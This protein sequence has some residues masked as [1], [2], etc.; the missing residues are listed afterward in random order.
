MNRYLSFYLLVIAVILSACSQ[1]TSLSEGPLYVG[2][3][4]RDVTPTE[5]NGLLPIPGIGRDVEMAGVINPI[6][7]RVIAFSKND[8]RALMICTETGKGPLG[9][10]FPGIISEHT[11]IP[12]ENIFYTTTHSHAAPEMVR[13][14]F[15]VE[16]RPDDSNTVK[17]ARLVL[18]S[19]LSAADEA[20][21][22]LQPVNAF[23]GVGESHIGVNRNY[24]Y[25]FEDGSHKRNLGPYLQGE[26]DPAL[27]VL[28]FDDLSG[29]PV[30][31]VMNY[32]C[33]AVTMI[34]NTCLDGAPG[35]DPDFPGQISRI[36]EERNPGAVAMWTSGAAGDINPFV[37]NQI[38]Y[39]DPDTGK[40]ITVH[41]GETKI[42]DQVAFIHYDDIKR[43]LRDGMKPLDVDILA[44]AEDTV[45]V[46]VAEGY[47]PACESLQLLRLG[48]MAFL[49]IPGELYSSVGKYVREHAPLPYVT[50]V[51]N[52]WNRPDS[53]IF[54]IEDD[55][56]VRDPGF[57][58]N[59]GFLPGRIGPCLSGLANRLIKDS[60]E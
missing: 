42:R 25:T 10:R 39:P 48:D 22:A 12:V 55:E 58:G 18:E 21:A 14:D 13:G 27:F 36:M 54:Y 50:V 53:D 1:K 24:P 2:A 35:V 49:G 59:H 43:V 56:G 41:S 52:T 46:P 34:A 20:L 23:I 17:W 29:Q 60:A 6:H 33:H 57:G 7:T 3:A 26:T 45:S 8:T 37:S 51:D 15:T 9:D 5:E 28:R 30:A 40:G 16:P 19:M 31:F 38:M 47:K 4:I 11:G 32:A 44:C